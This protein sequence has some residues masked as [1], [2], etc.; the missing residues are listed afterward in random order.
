M[1]VGSEE[2]KTIKGEFSLFYIKTNN[3]NRY[4]NPSIFD[5]KSQLL[6]SLVRACLMFPLMMMIVKSVDIDNFI[7][8][9]ILLFFVLF[10]CRF[11]VT[12]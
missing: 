8:K 5:I 12:R 4:Q 7:K 2:S 10:F 6:N 11:L 1:R 3:S 9:S